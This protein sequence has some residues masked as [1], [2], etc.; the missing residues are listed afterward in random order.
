M[1]IIFKITKMPVKTC[2]ATRN[3]MICLLQWKQKLLNFIYGVTIQ[4]KISGENDPFCVIQ[5]DS[6]HF[7]YSLSIGWSKLYIV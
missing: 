1:A 3:K 5:V 6:C 4:E 2:V 7:P